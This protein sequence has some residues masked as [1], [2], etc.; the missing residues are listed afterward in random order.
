MPRFKNIPPL[1]KQCIRVFYNI[2]FDYC[3]KLDLYKI[4]GKDIALTNLHTYLTEHFPICVLDDLLEL[5]TCLEHNHSQSLKSYYFYCVVVHK[6]TRCFKARNYKLDLTYWR[7]LFK[8]FFTNLVTLNLALSCNDQILEMIPIYCPNLEHLNATCKYERVEIGG[9]A[10]TF[11]LSVTDYGLRFL[12]QCKKLRTITVN[13]PRSNS[14][15]VQNGITYAGL[16]RLLIHVETLEDISYSDLGSVVC[17]GLENLQMLNLNIIR[18]FN[19][20]EDS[21]KEILRLCIHLKELYLTFFN[22]DTQCSVWTEIMHANLQ[23]RALEVINLN[24]SD[25]FS[26]LFRSIGQS[27]VF[28]SISNNFH[29]IT[30]KNLI[31]IGRFCPN[32]TFLNCSHLSNRNEITTY[33]E[34]FGQFIKLESLH[35]S[36]DYIDIQNVLSFCTE[37]AENLENLRLIEQGPITTYMDNIFVDVVHPS[38]IRHIEISIKLP[39][40][41]AG[42]RK[43]LAK[44]PL[45]NYL[46]VS[47]TDDCSTLFQEIKDMNYDLV[48]INKVFIP[49]QQV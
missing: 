42:I 4:P 17:K 24:C 41:T 14:R 1:Y 39:F 22:S 5:H 37:N 7:T 25:F 31:T 34:N 3:S 32:L 29:M 44:F 43:L 30:F 9:N 36:G 46:N 28:L 13:E 45:L 47:C 33:P 35:L 23:L 8:A 16:R 18:H 38:K 40:T 10:C 48:F 49:F 20:T 19:A 2:I 21:I 12:C 11:A 6:K 15:G 27:L 26:D